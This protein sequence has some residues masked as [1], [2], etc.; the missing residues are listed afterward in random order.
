MPLENRSAKAVHTPSRAASH[1]HNSSG[2]S[3]KAFQKEPIQNSSLIQ[4]YGER[5]GEIGAFPLPAENKNDPAGTQDIAPF[6]LQ[7]NHTV[8]LQTQPVVQRALNVTN[9]K[10]VWNITGRPAFRAFVLRTL[11]EKY[12]QNVEDEEDKFDIKTLSL[13]EEELDQ[14]HVM[15][16]ATIR[17][18]LVKAFLNETLSKGDFVAKTDALYGEETDSVEY[19]NMEVIRGRITD[20]IDDQENPEEGDI[21][22]L[23]TLLNSA[24]P[25]LRL[26]GSKINR[27]IKDRPDPHLESTPKGKHYSMTPNS[28]AILSENEDVM[29]DLLWTPEKTH[30]YNSSVGIVSPW[31]LTKGSQKVMGT[32]LNFDSDEES[33]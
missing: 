25:N 7:S 1:N 10:G 23:C 5:V 16:W 21:K 4:L 3:L 11:V 33:E 2:I 14:C 29:R 6:Q 9:K 30:F 20:A 15:A 28:R 27:K 17:D 22:E 26:D 24:T 18:E 19:E 12:N 32:K 31:R 8:L 13:T